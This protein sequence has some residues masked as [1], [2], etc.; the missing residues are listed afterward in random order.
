MH[1]FHSYE[2]KVIQYVEGHIRL[3]CN[4]K[5]QNMYANFLL[6][7]ILSCISLLTFH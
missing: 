3:L 7:S 1:V 6:F 2:L 5:Q 4:L